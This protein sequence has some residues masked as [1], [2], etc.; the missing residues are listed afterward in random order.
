M[1]TPRWM[2][3]IES[4]MDAISHINRLFSLRGTIAQSAVRDH[5]FDVDRRLLPAAQPFAWSQETTAAVLAA[6]Q[7][8]PADTVFNQWN[9]G[10]SAAWWWFEEPLPF[11][12][13]TVAEG[14]GKVRA[15]CFGQLF[16]LN[17]NRALT[18]CSVWCDDD[19]GIIKL[20][21]TVTPSQTWVWQPEQTVES[22]LAAGR[23]EYLR[24]YG[25]G[26]RHQG[27]PII[28]VEAFLEAA[29]GLSRFVLA[30]LAWLNQKV[31]V[32]ESERVERHRRKAFN[33][34]TGQTLDGVKVVQLRRAERTPSTGE[35][36]NREWSR[37]WVVDGHWR[38]QPCGPK[39]G[40]RRLA[41]IHPYV[42]G[43][44]DK[45]LVAKTK[46]YVVER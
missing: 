23:V 15:L 25:P 39:H 22:M 18:G 28:G 34:A 4:Q 7:S 37:R 3:A 26:G 16:D 38:N 44:D 45:P 27:A 46:V 29:G 41:Y 24:R 19:S 8:I 42:K 30:G 21:P 2:A 12:T 6:S 32:A 5:G 11:T 9:L 33:R 40:D 13:M 31:L 35:G 10:A 14:D 43:P 20:G 36:A 17:C 1:N